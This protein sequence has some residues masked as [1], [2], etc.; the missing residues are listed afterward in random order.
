MRQKFPAPGARRRKATTDAIGIHCAKRG[1][2]FRKR[3]KAPLEDAVNSHAAALQS[4]LCI[5]PINA[6]DTIDAI[7]NNAI[8]ALADCGSA[9]L[10][11]ELATFLQYVEEHGQG[12][13]QALAASIDQLQELFLATMHQA[14]QLAGV[15]VDSRMTIS[16][17]RQGGI[18]VETVC[19]EQAQIEEILSSSQALPALFKLIS[20]QNAILEGIANL[21]MVAGA[22]NK[23]DS[24]RLSLL[25]QL[26]RVCLKG[27][28]SHFYSA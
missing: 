20:A 27:Q 2:T 24:E 7:E 23:G 12:V 16:L 13:S 11:P 19:A 1:A 9:C 26:Y 21:R 18:H 10:S 28:L 14:F 3:K 8:Q 5:Q 17:N 4:M 22:Q 15:T 25:Q 6:Q